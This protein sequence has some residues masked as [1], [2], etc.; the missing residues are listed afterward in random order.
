MYTKEITSLQHP[1]VKHLVKLRQNK[2]YRAAQASA[3][4]VG[5]KLVNE[6]SSISKIHKLIIKKNFPCTLSSEETYIVNDAIF[7]KITGMQNTEGLLAEIPIP[8]L[9]ELKG[10]NKLIAF[11]G[12]K[13]PGNLGTLLRTALA[14]G[15]EGALLLN[16]TVDP[17]N[18]KAISAAKGATF[19]LPLSY[20]P[21]DQFKHTLYLGDISGQSIDDMTFETPFILV[22]G[23]ES[24]GPSNEIK[25]R[26]KAI[27]IPMTNKMESLNVA[28]AGGILMYR[29]THG[30]R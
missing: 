8:K 30:T 22:L 29:I 15:F 12:I 16:N 23:S 27:T 19:K 13:D 5:N 4:V 1:I 20:E 28:I 9:K 6:L 21:I 17:F 25:Q 7:T 26:A 2:S 3:L 10:S 11:D 14:F 24:H 18:E